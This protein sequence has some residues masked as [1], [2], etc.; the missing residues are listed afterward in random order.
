MRPAILGLLSYIFGCS[1]RCDA[2]DAHD[3]IS[4]LSFVRF[5]PSFATAATRVSASVGHVVALREKIHD[6]GFFPIVAWAHKYS[7]NR[8]M[9]ALALCTARLGLDRDGSGERRD[10]HLTEPP[11]L[12]HYGTMVEGLVRSS[13]RAYW[14]TTCQCHH[15]GGPPTAARRLRLTSGRFTTLP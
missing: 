11:T 4:K 10:P 6:Q 15:S 1:N 5:V 12:Q 2:N 9:V 3:S 13:G 8:F 14:I 7:R